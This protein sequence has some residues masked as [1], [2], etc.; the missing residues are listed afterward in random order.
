MKT[1]RRKKKLNAMELVINGKLSCMRR[2]RGRG[3]GGEVG[4]RD[5]E[6]ELWKIL[7]LACT[8]LLTQKLL[9]LNPK[10]WFKSNTNQIFCG[11]VLSF[12]AILTVLWI[13]LFNCNK[14]QYSL[15]IY[16]WMIQ[17]KSREIESLVNT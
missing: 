14:R 11:R 15:N 8:L 16:R 1:R 3:F 6:S 7:N 13:S 10:S 2:R 9:Q 5:R 17:R 12:I 4:G